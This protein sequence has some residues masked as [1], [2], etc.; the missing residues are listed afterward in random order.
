MFLILFFFF[1]EKLVTFGND[2]NRFFFNKIMRY[3][4]FTKPKLISW[5]EMG[6][7]CAILFVYNEELIKLHVAL[8]SNLKNMTNGKGK[9]REKRKKKKEI[10]IK[11]YLSVSVGSQIVA[12][13]LMETGNGPNK[14][15]T[16][17]L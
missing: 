11:L 1:Q 8:K 4:N 13:T 10:P 12:H 6:I 3:I 7:I 16:I 5:N 15:N 17:N 9:K 14:P 2:L